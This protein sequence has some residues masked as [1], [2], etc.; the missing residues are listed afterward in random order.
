MGTLEQISIKRGT[1]E[2]CSQALWV[3]TG[4]FSERPQKIASLEQAS[5]ILPGTVMGNLSNL[6]N[7]PVEHF[8]S[9]WQI[10]TDRKIIYACALCLLANG[11]CRVCRADRVPND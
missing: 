2:R 10:A 5:R 3:L 7:V 6:S 8:K 1:W 4:T 11:M 9:A